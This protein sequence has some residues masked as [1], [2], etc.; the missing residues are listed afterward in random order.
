MTD[1]EKQLILHEGKRSKPY[2]D[3]VGK[4]TIGIGR[5]LD[6]SGLSDSE[7]LYLFHNDILRVSMELEGAFPW[8]VRLSEHRQHALIDMTFNLGL[9][10]LLGFKRFLTAMAAGDF[11]RASVE[12]LDSKWAGQV[13][14][15]AQTLATMMVEG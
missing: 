9:S 4:L 11:N 10:R 6:D 3:S 5:N 13:G 12:M 2:R 8:F 14:L 15:R 7:I 1:L